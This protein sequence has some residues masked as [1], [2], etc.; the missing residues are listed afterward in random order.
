MGLLVGQ[1]L[2]GVG[3]WIS[4]G[5]IVFSIVERQGVTLLGKDEDLKFS[6]PPNRWEPVTSTGT[7]YLEGRT[8]CARL[9]VNIQSVR[10]SWQ[11][12]SHAG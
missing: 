1:I 6:T 4:F 2:L 3:L 7:P 10:L 9:A 12:G 11:G 5:K 8:V